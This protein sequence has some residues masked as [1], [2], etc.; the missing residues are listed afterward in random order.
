M[1]APPPSQ[2]LKSGNSQTVLLLP[3]RPLLGSEPF[4]R[5]ALE[6]F[7]RRGGPGLVWLTC[8]SNDCDL[9][10]WR[11]ARKYPLGSPSNYG[12]EWGTSGGAIPPPI[13]TGKKVSTGFL[14]RGALVRQAHALS[15]SELFRPLFLV[16]CHEALPL[17]FIYLHTH[18]RNKQCKIA[19]EF[20]SSLN[21]PLHYL[22]K[23]P[24][25]ESMR[26]P[27]NMIDGICN[28]SRKFKNPRSSQR[29]T[30]LTYLSMQTSLN[31]A[32]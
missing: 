28:Y 12:A 9:R 20:P 11:K 24:T 19:R 16:M 15:L 26:R 10:S 1:L 31:N 4:G 2:R 8:L 21:S 18:T 27:P 30:L 22:H 17:I 6:L 23:P 25:G 5:R 29:N 32:P 7:Q 14:D 13:I 3:V